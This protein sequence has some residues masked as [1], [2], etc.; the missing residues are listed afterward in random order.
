M[1][2][3]YLYA[4]LSEFVLAHGVSGNE[5]RVAEVVERRLVEI[6]YPKDR[7]KR[8]ALGN[9]WMEFG[10][11]LKPERLLVA[12]LDEIGFR[13]TSIRPDGLMRVVNV[14]GLDAQLY[15]GA[16]VAVHT[17]SGDIS[18]TFSTL[19]HHVSLRSSKSD[20]RRLSVEDL[21]LDIGATSADEVH[22]AGVHLLDTVTFPK[23]FEQLAGGFV[24]GRSLDDRF[25]C[26]ALV[27]LAE[28]L[29]NNE[30]PVPTVL[31]WSVQ[32]EVGLRGARALAERFKGVDEVIAIDSFTVGSGP[33][34]N[35]QFDAVKPGGGAVLR[36]FDSTTLVPDV[37]RKAIFEKAESLDFKLQYGYMPGGN[38]A[39]MFE[40]FGS[41]VFGFS[42]PVIYSHT[43]AERINIHDLASLIELLYAWTAT[44]TAL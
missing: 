33:R 34:D 31:A 7:I 5:A 15:E 17:T 1:D 43:A 4:L 38:D 44:D 9:R 10:G 29:F 19:S 13:I 25:G 6:G 11:S 12:H 35:K 39:S 26:T 30:P 37:T 36:A 28:Y 2:T 23:R 21:I 24:Q 16:P 3:Q 32:E 40:V 8:D 27:A 20:G 41:R 18:G 22:K 14:G 42:V